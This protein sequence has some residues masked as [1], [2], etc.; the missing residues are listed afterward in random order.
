MAIEYATRLLS[1]NPAV[2]E[3]DAAMLFNIQEDTAIQ[4]WEMEKTVKLRSV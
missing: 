2:A 4:H 1:T 3:C